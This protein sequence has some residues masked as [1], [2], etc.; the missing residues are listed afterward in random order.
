MSLL[1]AKRPVIFAGE[2]HMINLFAV[3]GEEP[4]AS[5][6][7]WRCTYSAHG[8]GFAFFFW[9]TADQ[10]GAESLPPAAIYA[11][12]AAMACMVRDRFNQYFAGF[13]ERGIASVAPQPA[14]FQQLGEGRRRHRIVC[15]AATHTIELCWREVF[16][17]ALEIFYN[18]SGPD[19]YDV[20]AV[21]CS[22]AAASITIDG[23]VLR[24][25]VRAPAGA[26]RSSA[27]LAF[28]ET[29]VEATTVE[30]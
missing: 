11:D 10:T 26:S 14:R 24:G 13:G 3:G 12:N 20:S 18:T 5:A 4:I 25:E 15:S 23:T 16:D 6:S 28:S 17:A 22:C 27:F 2:N 8:E 30:G 7:L 21:I 1:D 9:H 29:W 19:P